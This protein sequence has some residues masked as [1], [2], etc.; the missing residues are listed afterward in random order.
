[1]CKKCPVAWTMQKLEHVTC[2]NRLQINLV[3]HVGFQLSPVHSIRHGTLIIHPWWP[4]GIRTKV[5]V[6]LTKRSW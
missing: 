3:V 5:V 6:Y 4:V 1:M 2:L